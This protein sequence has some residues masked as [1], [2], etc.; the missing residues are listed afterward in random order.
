MNGVV[1][2]TRGEGINENEIMQKERRKIST[3]WERKFSGR[4]FSGRMVL[5]LFNLFIIPFIRKTNFLSHGASSVC[6][7]SRLPFF[8]LI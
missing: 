4:F 8:I 6:S 7:Y 1:D 3:L 2:M 5:R